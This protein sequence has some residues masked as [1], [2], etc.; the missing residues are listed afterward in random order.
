MT[1]V[2]PAF[3]SAREILLSSTGPCHAWRVSDWLR[4]ADFG[5]PDPMTA[6]EQLAS[7]RTQLEGLTDDELAGARWAIHPRDLAALRE[8]HAE[9]ERE[10]GLWLLV[11]AAPDLEGRGP[12]L[13]WEDA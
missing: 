8:E 5:R 11:V 4:P 3:G 13:V 7:A 10:L 6:S 9:P 12:V 1:W 2:Y